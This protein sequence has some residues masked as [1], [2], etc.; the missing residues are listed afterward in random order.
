MKASRKM[1]HNKFFKTFW[2]KGHFLP[3]NGD[4]SGTDDIQCILLGRPY[5][6]SAILWNKELSQRIAPVQVKFFKTCL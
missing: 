3:T 2:Q 1:V 6:G 5:G 4:T